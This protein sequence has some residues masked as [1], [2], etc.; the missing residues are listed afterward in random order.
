[1][2]QPVIEKLMED[3]P[4]EPSKLFTECYDLQRHRPSPEYQE[5]ISRVKNEFGD[6]GLRWE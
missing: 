2:F 3:S 5:H 4:P 1:M 6:C